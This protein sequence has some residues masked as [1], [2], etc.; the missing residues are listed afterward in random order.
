MKLYT[1]KRDRDASPEVGVLRGALLVPAG[2]FGLAFAS[3]NDLIEKATPDDLARMSGG[4]FDPASA[5]ELNA[6]LPMSP[7]P[8][9]RQDVLCLGLN[10]LAH[11]KEAH[12]FDAAF[13]T[14]EGWPVYFSK[15]VNYSQGDGGGIP[16][17]ADVTQKLD[18]EAEL[19]VIIGRDA[20]D[21]RP[22]DAREYVF[23]YT[24]FNDVTARDVQNRH[25]QWYYGKSFDGFAPMGPCIVTADE[26]PFP[27]VLRVSST[28]NGELRQDADTGM[29][30]H[31][32]PE[33]ISQFSHGVTLKAGTIIAT[34]TPQGVGMGMAEPRFLKKGDT[35]T[36][37]VE[38]IGTLTN[39]VM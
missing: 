28:V 22:E 14:N 25:V 11:A 26:F 32:I 27:P 10:Y 18:Y 15:R 3:M 34:G 1:Y 19:A 5:A 12:R 37:E 20:K 30:V 29:L 9:P 35:V 2:A 16:A 17:H 13:V 4:D 33:I 36:C 7:I 23:G 6:V 8:R 31:G 24:V 38:G 39:T 21:V